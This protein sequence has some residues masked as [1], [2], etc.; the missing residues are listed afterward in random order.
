MATAGGDSVGR[1]ETL[2]QVHASELAFW[3]KSTAQDIWTGL[4]QPYR[5][6]PACIFVESTADGITGVFYDLWQGAVAGTNGFVPVLIPQFADPTYREKAPANF[7]LTPEEEG[8]VEAYGLDNDQLQFRR[9]KIAERPRWV[10]RRVSESP[11]VC[12]SQ[13]RSPGL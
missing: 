8:L 9:M 2:T 11:G 12:V 10:Q 3:P 13:H 1:G 6:L 4:T 7:E 5:I